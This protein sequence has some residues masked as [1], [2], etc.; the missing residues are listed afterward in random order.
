MDRETADKE[1]SSTPNA[2]ISQGPACADLSGTTS[3]AEQVGTACFQRA[4]RKQAEAT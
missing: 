3:K 1:V 4:E 2:L